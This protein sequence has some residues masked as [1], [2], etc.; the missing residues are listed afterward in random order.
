MRPAATAAYRRFE[1]EG[2]VGGAAVAAASTSDWFDSAQFFRLLE[3]MWAYMEF[4]RVVTEIMG[5]RS[6]SAAT[7]P[8]FLPL[9]SYVQIQNFP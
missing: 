1:G 2:K 5:L 3:L 8:F 4:R 9:I 6:S 7:R